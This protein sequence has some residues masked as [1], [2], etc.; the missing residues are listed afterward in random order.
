MSKTKQ[1]K[2][3]PSSL[4]EEISKYDHLPSSEQKL[5]NI[6]RLLHIESVEVEF[7]AGGDNYEYGYV[8]FISEKYDIKSA[9]KQYQKEFD[10][11]INTIYDY[12]DY[13][14]DVEIYETS[15]GYYLGESG[16]III[17]L[18]EDD[19]CKLTCFKDSISKYSYDVAAY[20]DEKQMKDEDVNFLID[21]FNN[22][23]LIFELDDFLLD[24]SIHIDNRLR[25]AINW[26]SQ[27]NIMPSDKILTEDQ[28]RKVCHI[29]IKYLTPCMLKV[30]DII[31]KYEEQGDIIDANDDYYP[32][33]EITIDKKAKN[34]TMLYKRTV[35]TRY[36]I[37]NEQP[38]EVELN[39][40][41]QE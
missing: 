12:L 40:Y 9:Q 7:D 22:D 11:V 19:E 6:F 17:S 36:D 26:I 20:I 33:I 8:N 1:S 3:V 34:I 30:S 25:D 37:V 32:T 38:Y 27:D 23:E 10:T 21:I 29:F 2:P 15:D 4:I 13:E 24:E 28:L 31:N 39:N 35:T 16:T 18:S 41:I 5:I 14:S